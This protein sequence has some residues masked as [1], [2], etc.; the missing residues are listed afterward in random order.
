MGCGGSKII[1]KDK[2]DFLAMIRTMPNL[3]NYTGN[4]KR[5]TNF[6]KAWVHPVFGGSVLNPVGKLGGKRTRYNV[7]GQQIE[8]AQINQN[9]GGGYYVFE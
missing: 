9:W 6:T 3:K 1:Q 8:K 2:N 4:A 7:L 5:V